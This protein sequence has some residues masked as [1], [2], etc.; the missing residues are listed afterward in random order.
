MLA[1]PTKS[2]PLPVPAGP[3][4]FAFDRESPLS[5][6]SHD[7]L[8]DLRINAY[9]EA[10]VDNPFG[11]PFRVEDVVSSVDNVAHLMDTT[12]LSTK[13]DLDRRAMSSSAVADAAMVS[14][15]QQQ[16]QQQQPQQQQQQQQETFQNELGNGSDLLWKQG[17]PAV[18]GA[19]MM[20]DDDDYSLSSSPPTLTA[21]SPG[22]NIVNPHQ[23][24]H[25][26]QQQQ[27]QQHFN[28]FQSQQQQQHTS[29]PN[30][31]PSHPSGFSFAASALSSTWSPSSGF[32]TSWN[33]SSPVESNITLAQSP[34]DNIFPIDDITIGVDPKAINP[35][36]AEIS[37]MEDVTGN[38]NMKMSTDTLV[39]DND[40][41]AAEDDFPAPPTVP[42][43]A[44][45]LSTLFSSARNS[46]LGVSVPVPPSVENGLL[47]STSAPTFSHLNRMNQLSQDASSLFDSQPLASIPASLPNSTPLTSLVME[48]SPSPPN[49]STKLMGRRKSYAGSR[50]AS[51]SLSSSLSAS[52]QRSI[53]R[54]L[55]VKRRP[56]SGG[57]LSVTSS[58]ASSA[59][60]SPL[61]ASFP[62]TGATLP[63]AFLFGEED[64]DGEIE[65]IEEVS[66]N[67]EDPSSDHSSY[68]GSSSTSSLKKNGPTSS[69]SS[70]SS[71]ATSPTD[72]NAVNGPL[73]TI[74]AILLTPTEID[75]LCAR[76][77]AQVTEN[78]GM[79]GCVCGKSYGTLAALKNHAKLHTARER[80]FICETCKKAFL[81]KQDLK[82]H[83]TTHLE[84]YHPYSCE[85]CG[86]TFTR[87][88]ALSRHIK[89]RR[90]MD[91]K[92]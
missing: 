37:P 6:L 8:P 19:D 75:S 78:G 90:C 63:S 33:L 2:K 88:D 20:L 80:N 18:P 85:N 22:I 17:Y 28:L 52:S 5:H 30:S 43:N 35:M 60:T 69:S 49:S 76:A 91:E 46:M 25:H 12:S 38:S 84:D 51:S 62:R 71:L 9:G 53:S 82:R 50:S 77:S 21:A 32:P 23:S 27:Q 47:L 54:S 39:V 4:A 66:D 44:S 86:T 87:S 92:E 57:R 56:S 45:S 81:R 26:Y 48:S 14:L 42:S 61:S 79:Y 41:F 74:P 73:I 34:T 70:T 29:F 16:Q 68:G 58:S 13:A 72:P 36:L 15:L 65:G 24:H 1:E 59:S 7:D 89:A 10:D 31:L 83:E 3:A 64:G 55:S 40:P 11:L 67:E